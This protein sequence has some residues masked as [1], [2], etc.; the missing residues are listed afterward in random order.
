MHDA[1]MC[2]LAEP[3]VPVDDVVDCGAARS[4]GVIRVD[5]SGRVSRQAHEQHHLDVSLRPGWYRVRRLRSRDELRNMEKRVGIGMLG[6]QLVQEVDTRHYEILKIFWWHGME[7]K[8]IVNLY[9]L[10]VRDRVEEA[11][12]WRKAFSSRQ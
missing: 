12:E 11:A 1:P 10:I 8:V 6:V 7:N 5:V 2:Q 3:V 9:E 4:V